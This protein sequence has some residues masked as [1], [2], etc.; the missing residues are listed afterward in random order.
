[1][2]PT[3]GRDFVSSEDRKGGPAVVILSHRLWQSR[4]GSD[5]AII[6]HTITLAGKAQTVV[7]VL[8]A[9]FVFPDPAVE[10]DLYIPAAIEPDTDLLTTNIS[11][12]TVSTIARLRHGVTLPQ[13]QAEL[14]LFE[15]NRVKGYGPFFLNWAQGRRIIAEPL[16]SYLT[17]DDREPLLILLACV[18]A[19]LLIACANIAS[20]QLALTIAREPEMA[21]RGALGAGRLR[22]IRQSLVENLT[23]SAMASVLGLA[24]AAAVTGLIRR[25]GMPGAFS[26]GSSVADLLQ[27]PFG[28]LSAAV[29]LNGWVL[30]FTAGLALLTTLLWIGSGDQLLARRS[31]HLAAERRRPRFLRPSAPS[32]AQCAARRGDRPCRALTYR[33]GIAHP[34]L[35]ACA[36]KWRRVRSASMSHR[37]NAAQPCGGSG[38]NESVCATTAAAA[39]GDPWRVACSHRQCPSAGTYLPGTDFCLWRWTSVAGG[40]APRSPQHQHQ[41]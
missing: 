14:D 34:Q 1:V 18:A 9:H 10:P 31:A 24:I 12:Y 15:Q 37:E 33:R 27:A 22:L 39:L 29:D 25:S 2:A 16:Q 4:F 21:L 26:S 28:K 5:P 7:G 32:V 36:A 41:P 30:T 13:V 17:G 20:L 8:P 3:L 6:G 19:V 23:L 11:I 35:C 38:K 40:T